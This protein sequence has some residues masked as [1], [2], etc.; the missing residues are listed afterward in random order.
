MVNIYGFLDPNRT[1]FSKPWNEDLALIKQGEKLHPLVA[2]RPLKRLHENIINTRELFNI[3]L[4]EPIFRSDVLIKENLTI[5][6]GLQVDEDMVIGGDLEFSSGTKIQDNNGVL[7]FEVPEEKDITVNGKKIMHLG[8]DGHGSGFDA[9]KLDGHDASYFSKKSDLDDH[10]TDYNNPHG[11][12]LD[13]VGGF[14]KDGGTINGD[15]KVEGKLSSGDIE[16]YP[17]V[18]GSDKKTVKLG[19]ITGFGGNALVL[20][21]NNAGY[22][23]GQDTGVMYAKFQMGN[24]NYEAG[25]YW[26]Q[27]GT[28]RDTQINFSY[29]FE[30]ANK[31][32]V[33]VTVGA[34]TKANAFVLEGYGFN[35]T[36]DVVTDP[37]GA[38]LPEKY[39][40]QSDLT[41][42]GNGV[43]GADT[44][45]PQIAVISGQVEHGSALPLPDGYTADQCN[46]IVSTRRM[47]KDNKSWDIDENGRH[48]MLRG[49]CKVENGV[50]RAYWYAH[51]HSA[52]PG[53]N[54]LESI[55]NYLVIG[56]K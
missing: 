25:G 48:I 52:T 13:D 14:S 3:W 42:K 46:W 18:S 45:I 23:Y 53:Y 50:V 15:L 29:K 31:I 22:G 35:G 36:F 40:L 44:N 28:K 47:N 54:L 5:N 38:N 39:D 1:D 24:Q 2:N 43:L 27:E 10:A 56:V 21:T 12:V 55:A 9:D 20:L 19:T 37:Y 8:N 11:V 6:G 51:G 16:G 26:Y 33:Y 49:Y 41:V 32:G 7:N 17:I 30:E 34:Y 4:N